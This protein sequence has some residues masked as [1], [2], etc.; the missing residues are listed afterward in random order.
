LGL[1]NLKSADKSIN[2][3]FEVNFLEIFCASPFG[4]AVNNISILSKFMLAKLVILGN[5]FF[6]MKSRIYILI[7]Q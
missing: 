2:L 4:S 3:F 1:S 5:D 7:Y 6:L